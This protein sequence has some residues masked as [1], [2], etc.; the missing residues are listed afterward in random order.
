M[1]AA[2]WAWDVGML[3]ASIAKASRDAAAGRDKRCADLENLGVRNSARA[4]VGHQFRI[5]HRVSFE[6]AN[7]VL[8]LSVDRYLTEARWRISA[9]HQ[10]ARKAVP[11]FLVQNRRQLPVSALREKMTYNR[12]RFH[13]RGEFHASPP[14]GV[15]FGGMHDHERSARCRRPTKRCNPGQCGFANLS[16]RSHRHVSAGI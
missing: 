3:L 12:G 10:Q 9:S 5:A 13:Q 11:A 2:A 14:D 16:A 6:L 8:D 7:I 4:A 1:L 15:I